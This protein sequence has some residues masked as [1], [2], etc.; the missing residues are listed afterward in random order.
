MRS[1][2]VT[3]ADHLDPGLLPIESA[4]IERLFADLAQ[5]GMV[6]DEGGGALQDAVTAALLGRL[7]TPYPTGCEAPQREVLTD[8]AASAAQARIVVDGVVLLRPGGTAS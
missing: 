3:V 5:A 2:S 1:G 4:N 7:V 6:V 8:C